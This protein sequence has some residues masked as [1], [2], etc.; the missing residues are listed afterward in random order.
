M[1]HEKY[2]VEAEQKIAEL[3]KEVREWREKQLATE[4]NVRP[5]PDDDVERSGEA[6]RRWWTLGL[7]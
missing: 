2:K 6:P 4:Q 3:E 5:R 1:A 7:L